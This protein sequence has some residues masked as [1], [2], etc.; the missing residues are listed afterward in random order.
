MENKNFEVFIGKGDKRIKLPGQILGCN[1][2]AATSVS[3]NVN[4]FLFIGSGNFHPL[5]LMLITKK[6]VIACDPYTNEVKEKELDDLKEMVLRQR[7]GAIARSKNA[8]VF[9]ILIGTKTGQQQVD[10]AYKIKEK[11]NT[12]EKKSYFFVLNNFTPLK[13]QSFLGI[14]C[15]ISTA[16]PRIAIDDYLQYKIP[17]ITPVELDIL[18]GFKKWDEYCFDEIVNK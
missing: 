17:I 11:L 1:F 8:R 15:L 18:L 6:K 4:I 10:L 12:Y 13:I 9:G 16:C 5:G 3:K 2:S 14:D 7:Y